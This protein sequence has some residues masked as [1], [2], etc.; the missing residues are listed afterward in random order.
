MNEHCESCGAVIQ[1]GNKGFDE[2]FC[3]E[4]FA[5]TEEYIDGNWP[6]EVPLITHRKDATCDKEEK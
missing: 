3:P 6:Q 1:K 5:A 2:G 4:C